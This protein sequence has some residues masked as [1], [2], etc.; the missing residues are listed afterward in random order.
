MNKL[1]L[2]L[3]VTLSIGG[4]A[5]AQQV[6]QLNPD[7]A[8]QMVKNID[9]ANI[10]QQVPEAALRA[11]VPQTAKT[12][13]TPAPVK[14]VLKRA[15]EQSVDT[16]TYFIV[17]KSFYQGYTFSYSDG[18]VDT[19]DIGVAVDGTKVTFK[20][21]FNL[22]NPTDYTPTV[23]NDLVGTYDASAKTITIPTP[24]VFA[25]ATQVA[26]IWGYYNGVLSSGEV[27]EDGRMTPSEDLVFH[28]DGDFDRIYTDQDFGIA[29]Y[30]KDGSQSYG[31]YSPHVYDT[32]SAYKKSDDGKSNLITPT[33]GLSFGSTFPSQSVTR[34]MTLV[35]A[36]SADA[37]YVIGI[38]SDPENAF[39]ADTI[40]NTVPAYGKKT[41]TYTLNSPTIGPAEGLAQIESDDLE[42]PITVNLD[43]E[44][45]PQPDFS[46]IVKEGDMSFETNIEYPFAL[47]TLANGQVVASSMTRGQGNAS[48]K[49][50]V[51]VDVPDGQVGTF[52]WKGVSSNDR[53]NSGY[54][55][56]AAGGYFVDDLNTAVA[57]YN[58]YNVNIDN[59]IE[60]GPGK[61]Q[62]RFQFDQYYYTG[63]NDSRMYLYDLSFKTNTLKADTAT[64]KTPNVDLG[65][66]VLEKESMVAGTGSITIQNR[67]A[68]DLSVISAS[69][70]NDEFVPDAAVAAVKTLGNLEIPV[71]FTSETSGHKTATITINTSAG[72][73]KANISADVIDNP[74]FS[75]IVD[76]G[77][78][79]M[80]FENNDSH[81]FVV[82]NGVAY[83]YNWNK[84]T[85][86]VEPIVSSFTVHITIPEGKLG[87]LSWQGRA[88]AVSQADYPND[89]WAHDYGEVDFQHQMN[90]GSK[91]GWGLQDISS[92]KLYDESWD[93]YLAC[94]PGEHTFTFEYVQ[95]GDSMYTG[96]NRA[97]YSHLR[98]H[99]TDFSDHAVELVD[100][101]TVQ[102]EPTYVG[103]NRYTTATI[104]LRNIGTADLSID[105]IGASNNGNGPFYGIVPTGMYNK[106]GFNEELPVTL[107]FYPT[108]EGEYNDSLLISTNAGDIWVKCHGNTK[109]AAGLELIGDFEDAAYGWATADPD[110][111]GE[112]WNLGSNLWGD[113]PRYVHSGHDCLASISFSNNLGSITPNNWTISPNVTIPADGAT[114]TYYVAAFHPERYAEHYSL[115]ITEN[116]SQGI[117]AISN[118][119]PVVEE[120]LN[121]PT[122]Q[123]SLGNVLGWKKVT[124]DLTPYAGKTINLAF[125]HHDCTG[126]YILR[127]D[128][129]FIFDKGAAD[130][131]GIGKVLATGDAAKVV[132]TEYFTLDGART[133]AL[134]RG[135]NIVRTTFAD[136]SVRSV[137]VL[138]K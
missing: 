91:P 31:F 132:K 103:Y 84:D 3:A 115:Y 77:A 63:S 74:D 135:V 27:N 128:D 36:G 104:N 126:Q 93:Q 98:L 16:V 67:G 33:E 73:F 127:L 110:G 54:Y 116:A 88:D 119:T 78:E 79:Y 38:E 26:S 113:V 81:P 69:S 96:K 117:E 124:V 12:T 23:E 41:I 51:T 40:S 76:E 100:T 109:P 129:V 66:F 20:G 34:S 19:Y 108:A 11:L 101:A 112:T 107:W 130:P 32:F 86:D 94:T 6:K 82:D 136:G 85:I 122:S 97:E 22:Y 45:V 75:Q 43:G 4:V 37:E 25:N 15:D 99:V 46:P 64:L 133:S 80:T 49:L 21:L 106:A 55:Y 60:L 90:S 56:Y 47:D 44:I 70:D 2:T 17:G 138:N 39:T 53:A 102:F 65:N 35:N 58:G 125:R 131:T 14:K 111:D 7:Q 50:T 8:R 48:S 68:N 13:A 62:I 92:D 114:L 71:T 24:T 5:S 52:S 30:S 134:T 10:Q 105:S 57:S 121:T 123:D 89:Y 29:E 9:P 87:R 118:E 28:V 61:H 59:S 83:N 42:D 137:K 72:E 18:N 120:T 95:Y 1:L